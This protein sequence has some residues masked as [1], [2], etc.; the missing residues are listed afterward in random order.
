MASKPNYYQVLAAALADFE[1]HGFDSQERLDHWLD[2]LEEAA[3]GS[4]VDEE[5]I[6]R[7]LVKHLHT[8]LDRTLK[9]RQFSKAHAGLQP[10][11]LQHIKPKLHAELQN[12]IIASTNLI[13]LN[14]AESIARARARLAGWMSSIPPGGKTGEDF[15]ES[16]KTVRRGIA[17]E[18]FI[19]R[20]V[21][22]DQG[23]KLNAAIND[24]VAVDGGAIIAT[25][26][27]VHRGLPSY[28]PRPEHV[29]RDGKVFVIPGNW[30]LKEGLMKPAG[31][32]FTDEIE[33]PGEFVYCLPGDT[34]IPFADGV[35]KA[36]RRWYCGQLTEFVTASGKTLRATP[37]HPVLTSNGWIASGALQ[38]GDDVI[39]VASNGIDVTKVINEN[40]A[41]P[42]ISEIF[43][44]LS[45]TATVVRKVG[46]R[47]W[48][49]GDGIVDSDVDIVNTARPLMFGL[50]SMKAKFV[51]QFD[52]SDTDDF[53]FRISA[54]YSFIERC[55]TATA[56][57]M[58][59][60]DQKLFFSVAH[61]GAA[62]E[63]R[64]GIVAQFEPHVSCQHA[65]RHIESFRDAQ[66][67]FPF[68]VRVTRIVDIKNRA[69]S[70]HVYNLETNN[71]AYI[72]EGIVTHN[73]GCSYDY[74]YNLR[75]LPPDML[76]AKGKAELESVRATMAL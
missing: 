39:E 12:R 16:T 71:S 28:H 49:H 67:A 74:G 41:I 73:C 44:A 34:R 48:F 18:T 35:R 11:R 47:D 2:E 20:R 50:E 8:V 22:I 53:G 66:Q 5:T 7:D 69:W 68:E 33:Q 72:A 29:A 9:G 38:K 42:R 37:N 4:W 36:Y 62:Q 58:G 76:T 51:Q 13:K 54:F 19:E 59:L 14:R 61:A 6:K 1:I 55:A 57:L 40:S 75:D 21:I 60:S 26:R 70:G 10:F 23:H 65:S 52:F 46:I 63:S 56:S 32:Q 30:A 27:H 45:E 17:G 15:K 31:H 43:C 3:R 64:L 25:W 24:I